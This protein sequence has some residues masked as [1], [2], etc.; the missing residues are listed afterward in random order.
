MKLEL[1]KWYRIP[2]YNGY[3][4]QLTEQKM[5]QRS[6]SLYI[7]HSNLH[8]HFWLRSFKNFKKHKNGYIL[9]YIHT[10]K[11]GGH[12]YY[13]ELTDLANK[14]NR[15]TIGTIIKSLES[16]DIDLSVFDEY[17]NYGSRNR[18]LYKTNDAPFTLSSINLV[19][20]PK[21]TELVTFY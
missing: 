2:D 9:P 17:T 13:Y 16:S 8:C 3:E 15:I 11:G 10:A 1:N 18:A 20:N 21:H 5:G 6:H 14:R 7:Q 19:E 4:L 12:Q